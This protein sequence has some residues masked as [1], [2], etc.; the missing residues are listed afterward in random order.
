MNDIIKINAMWSKNRIVNVKK[1]I[2]QD[3]ILS[4]GNWLDHNSLKAK[5]YFVSWLDLSTKN[6]VH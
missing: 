5:V 2:E 3:L 4:I 6:K 1:K